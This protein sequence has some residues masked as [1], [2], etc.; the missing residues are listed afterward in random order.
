MVDFTAADFETP[1]GPEKP[2]PFTAADFTGGGGGGVTAIPPAKQ[3]FSASDFDIPPAKKPKEQLSI[4][5]MKKNLI[6]FGA[7]QRPEFSQPGSQSFPME[8]VVGAGEGFGEVSQGMKDFAAKFKSPPS[9]ET[10]RGFQRDWDTTPAIGP[11][12]QQFLSPKELFN[13]DKN[14]L[15][16]L[17]HASITA[18]NTGREMTMGD[19]ALMSVP[20]A[21]VATMAYGVASRLVDAPL[22][23]VRG[24][25]IRAVTRALVSSGLQ[26]GLLGE[27]GR[28]ATKRGFEAFRE[29]GKGKYTPAITP[30]DIG[31]HVE[32]VNTFAALQAKL[33]NG[34]DPEL[35]AIKEQML[36]QDRAIVTS[37]LINVQRRLG[38][39]ETVIVP[40]IQ[41]LGDIIPRIK[42]EAQ[43]SGRPEQNFA[44]HRRGDGSFDVAVYGDKGPL[45]DIDKADQFR[46]YGFFQGQ[47]VSIGGKDAVILEPHIVGPVRVK[48]L[49]SS[50][51]FDAPAE[52]IRR[53]PVSKS[54]LIS[55]E[56]IT[57]HEPQD[58]FDILL[59]AKEGAPAE[60]L[61]KLFDTNHSPT[62]TTIAQHIHE[63]IT[64]LGVSQ[65]MKDFG[66]ALAKTRVAA[67]LKHLDNGRKLDLTIEREI[68]AKATAAGT[69]E[70]NIYN[71]EFIKASGDFAKEHHKLPVFNRVQ[72]LARR[73]AVEIGKEMWTEARQHLYEIDDML[74]TPETWRIAVSDKP[75]APTVIEHKTDASF[76][77]SH[78]LNKNSLGYV[79]IDNGVINMRPRNSNRYHKGNGG[80]TYEETLSHEVAHIH[81]ERMIK[82]N[83]ELAMEIYRAALDGDLTKVHKETS[84]YVKM[85]DKE[86]RHVYDTLDKMVAEAVTEELSRRYPVT[87]VSEMFSIFRTELKRISVNDTYVDFCKFYDDV[88][89][90]PKLWEGKLA[91]LVSSPDVANLENGKFATPLNMALKYF[92]KD[93][94][95]AEFMRASEELGLKPDAETVKQVAAYAAV[96]DRFTLANNFDRLLERF[97]FTRGYAKEDIP[98]LNN[99]LSQR[100]AR[101]MREQYMEPAELEQF[102]AIQKSL[103]DRL[104][105]PVGALETVSYMDQLPI[106]Q[107]AATNGYRVEYSPN[108]DYIL[109]DMATQKE[110]ARFNSSDQVRKFINKSGQQDA[111]ELIKKGAEPLQVGGGA[112][113]PSGA[114]PPTFGSH[115]GGLGALYDAYEKG[116]YGTTAH[117]LDI[118]RTAT[119]WFTGRE[120]GFESVGNL[121]KRSFGEHVRKVMVA[122]GV[123]KNSAKTFAAKFL[124]HIRPLMKGM[125]KDQVANIF[126]YIEAMSPQELMKDML[127]KGHTEAIDIAK[128]IA[129]LRV[130]TSK[131]I[132]YSRMVEAIKKDFQGQG[133]NVIHDEILKLTQ[134]LKMEPNDVIAAGLFDGVRQ[135]DINIMSVLDVSRLADALMWDSPDRAGFAKLA[136]MS[137][138]EI[139]VANHFDNLFEA[140]A[141]IRGIPDYRKIRGY[142]AHIRT[143]VYKNLPSPESAFLF[144]KGLGSTLEGQF[145]SEF[146]RTGEIDA[147]D[148]NPFNVAV[149][150]IDTAFK[151]RDFVPVYREALKGF[152]SEISALRQ[153]GRAG[154]LLAS[155]MEDR[156]RR[157]LS[158]IRG[159]PAPTNM[160]IRSGI[161]A[162][163]QHLGL[164]VPP[165]IVETLVNGMLR[166]TSAA[167]LAARP[168]IGLRHLGQFFQNAGARFGFK[169]MMD[170]LVTAEKPGAIEDLR[171]RGLMSDLGITAL[172]TPEEEGASLLAK[173]G[174]S[175]WDAYKQ[176]EEYGH[177]ATMLPTIY[178]HTFAA[179]FYGMRKLALDN[180][181]KVVKG[182]ISLRK[183]Y[184]NIS[185]DSFAPS[186]RAEFDKAV[187]IGVD[188][189]ADL[190]GR[191][192]AVETIFEYQRANAPKGWNSVQGRLLTQYGTWSLHESE[193]VNNMLTRGTRRHR[194]NYA[195]RFA[196]AQGATFLA[197]RAIGIDLLGA[198]AAH[199][200]F[201]SGSP[202]VQL[203]Q[204]VATAING[205]GVEQDL[206]K[207]RL[208]KLVPSL[209]DPRSM[210]LPGSYAMGDWMQAVKEHNDP[211]GRYSATQQTGR[212]IGAPSIK[213]K[214]WVDDY[215]ESLG[216]HF[217]DYEKTMAAEGQ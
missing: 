84:E 31:P 90:H 93:E 100:F 21:M 2:K 145:V 25:G 72:M 199:S 120:A 57:G 48:Y 91:D 28:I 38:P 106:S 163:N 82:Y 71:D 5:E 179:T 124:E 206:A 47:E 105:R 94:V 129:D 12:G 74:Q 188:G 34:A 155:G 46:K 36:S 151:Q 80:H 158:D 85:I 214:S 42:Q 119:D 192:A 9:L 45:A 49:D 172:V 11:E 193:M 146:V 64:D 195:A 156:V 143:Q 8:A 3:Q 22:A 169:A 134:A 128:Q 108:G 88:M 139:V 53:K 189:A 196:M 198:T 147:L 211:W 202:Q 13:G 65:R 174:G 190:I 207:K 83:P 14:K 177:K 66:Y 216:L 150:Y 77:A 41:S 96:L 29:V 122:D 187:K 217:Y 102:N 209:D 200:L 144:Q 121:F 54:G 140:G 184:D 79:H 170:G 30:E 81:A 50:N 175:A 118:W 35:V 176:L 212:A 157:F 78:P 186:F 18:R 95:V 113:P 210:F 135:R 62:F 1:Q 171:S 26:F 92:T 132:H 112:M 191:R 55:S 203:A 58:P 127:A 173:T 59:Q 125:N 17:I 51:E 10:L 130:N 213:H 205:Y 101:D 208:F 161:E 204:T 180:L 110:I 109:H 69:P 148:L 76:E 23:A 201:W 181:N 111:P 44:I 142:I 126:R 33:K 24:E 197:G 137:G 107:E 153:Q 87:P 168:Y 37:A 133:S 162:M 104:D 68:D 40:G 70:S 73:A 116:T 52:V 178:E 215:M 7:S 89:A 56:I 141:N 20:P 27:G 32:S 152:A 154:R 138:K 136:G 149:R 6:D 194:V 182:E 117:I 165:N 183:A 185:L 67:L 164:H 61:Q 160:A 16:R 98:G 43:R 123:A 131:A 39:S 15:D 167:M 60:A 103:S 19:V 159:M 4:E 75:I 115:G 86:H 63:L 166:R 97:A 99:F 114:K